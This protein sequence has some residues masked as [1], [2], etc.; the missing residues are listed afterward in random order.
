M[1]KYN[2]SHVKRGLKNPHRVGLE[3]YKLYQ[4][5]IL[6]NTGVRILDK[7]W[8]NLIILD[9]CRYD[10]FASSD[11]PAGQ[12]QKEISMG[13]QTEEFLT[14]NFSSKEYPEITYVS[15]NPNIKYLNSKFYKRIR[16]WEDQWDNELNVVHPESVTNWIIENA[17]DHVDKR[18]IIHY[19]QPHY[20]FIGDKGQNLMASAEIDHLTDGKEFWRQYKKL[21]ERD[22]SRFRKAYEENLRIALDQVDRALSFLKGKTVI[23]S[24]HGNEFGKWGIYGHPAGV[25]SD[26]LVEVPWLVINQEN[27][28]RKQIIDGNATDG[29]ADNNV[30]VE[31]RLKYLGYK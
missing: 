15:A 23:T 25:Y 9:G 11:H 31:E 24:D 13:S 27:N 28:T 10:L 14:K 8:D 26:G 18:L 30:L 12:L 29:P 19:M 6:K 4:R 20:P 17:E 2:L 21:S 1:T 7:D 5:K 3:I 22:K 16:L